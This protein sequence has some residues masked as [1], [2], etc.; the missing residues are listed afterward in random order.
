M[1]NEDTTSRRRQRLSALKILSELGAFSLENASRLR[2]LIADDDQAIAVTACAICLGGNDRAD[3][4]AAAL[5]MFDLLDIVDWQ[6]SEEIERHLVGH[7]AFIKPI[8]KDY[9]A[10]REIVGAAK[11]SPAVTTLLR[12]LSRESQGGF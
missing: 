6:L 5:R 9:I 8:V 12:V 3:K 7:V 2:K 10:E 4:S 11:T 1:P